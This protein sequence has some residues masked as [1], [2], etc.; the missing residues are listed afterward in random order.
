MNQDQA[1]PERPKPLTAQDAFN[2]VVD[3]LQHMCAAYDR[4]GRE[5]AEMSNRAIR[6][7]QECIGLKVSIGR[8]TEEKG[9]PQAREG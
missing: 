8:L 1:A 5:L 4:Q 2:N 9:R 3:R 7:E 6:A